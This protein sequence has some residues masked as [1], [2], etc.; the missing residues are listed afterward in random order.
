MFRKF[1]RIHL[2]HFRVTVTADEMIA[3]FNVRPRMVAWVIGWNSFPSIFY[4]NFWL[5][6]VDIKSTFQ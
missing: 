1:L 4:K 3:S 5:G 6:P 2:G